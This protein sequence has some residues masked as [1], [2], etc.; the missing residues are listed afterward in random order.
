M[1]V[2][3]MAILVTFLLRRICL[4]AKMNK[5]S[6]KIANE[7]MSV[8]GDGGGALDFMQLDAGFG[9]FSWG[10]GQDS[11]RNFSEL[12]INCNLLE[13]DCG[14]LRKSEMFLS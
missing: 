5:Y 7:L 2:L 4:F 1:I 11:T 12:R 6:S 9:L 3:I 8:S 13:D 10:C 14:M